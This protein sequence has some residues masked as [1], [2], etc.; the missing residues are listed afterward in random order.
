MSQHPTWVEKQMSL[1]PQTRRIRV[2]VADH[3]KRGRK[4]WDLYRYI[5]DPYLLAD[6]LKLVLNNCGCAGLDRVSVGSIKGNEWEFVKS[7]SAKLREAGAYQPGA[8]KRVY[9][10]KSNGEKRPLGIPNLEDRVVQRA[11]VLLLE[12]VYEQRFYDFSYGF[13]PKRKAIDCVAIVAKQAYRDRHVLEAD[14]E[15]FFDQV[16]HNKLLKFLTKEIAD[17]RIMRLISRILKSGFQEPG[18]PWQPS[19]KGTPQGGPL[20][21]LLANVYLHHVL[22]EKFAEVYGQS[23]SVKLFRYADD[24][25]ITARTASELKTARRFLYVWM[26]GG[27]LSLKESKT[28]E[29]D[30]SNHRRGYQSQFD[31]LGF[32]IHLRAFADNPQRFWIARQPSEKSRRSLKDSLREKLKIHLTLAEARQVV[33]SVWRGWCN[34]FRYSN[35]NHI[36]YR[37]LHSVRRLI[38]RYLRRKY[39]RQRRPVPWRKL[40]KLAQEIWKPLKPIGV[41]PNHLCHTQP[42]LL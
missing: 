28:R 15:N 7:L 12:V 36:F 17:P 11:L 38:C 29:V 33:L 6:A 30:M 2:R 39:R 42:R 8:V 13:R 40:F 14:I 1:N 5:T 16:S 23:S 41:V 37:E 21:P 24:F 26:K 34:Y 25:I 10:P 4:Q 19:I 35:A 31:F 27:E 22:D 3:A 32:K 18:K 20:S 9:I